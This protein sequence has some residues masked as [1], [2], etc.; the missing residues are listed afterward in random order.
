EPAEVIDERDVR[1]VDVRARLLRSGAAYDEQAGEAGRARHARQVLDRPE[2]VAV[3][4]RDAVQLAL[5]ERALRD[6]ARRP[7]P[8]HGH[9]LVGPVELDAGRGRRRLDLLAGEADVD[10]HL[11]PRVDRL[12]VGLR[13]IARRGDGDLVRARG[14]ALDAP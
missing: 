6:L 12:L 1:P 11:G 5:L 13:R 9:L 4:A 2:R 7:R 8:A 10:L 3:R 14:D